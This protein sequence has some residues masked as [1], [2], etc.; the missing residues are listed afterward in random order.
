MLMNNN[1]ENKD[2]IKIEKATLAAGC[3]WGV[4]ASFQQ[5]DGVVSTRVGYTGGTKRNPTYEDVCTGKTGH[6]EAVEVSF[7]SSKI[8]YSEILDIFWSIHDPTTLNRQGLDIG[9]QY[10]SAI[11]CHSEEQRTLAIVSKE[12]MKKSGKYKRDIVTEIV[13]A[14]DFYPAEEYHQNYF[15]KH[16]R[17]SCKV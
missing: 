9:S 1:M 4:E 8:S 5:V 15:W 17:V 12:N 2:P 14:T 7:N 16:G 10:R 13:S 3:F 6:A 11:F